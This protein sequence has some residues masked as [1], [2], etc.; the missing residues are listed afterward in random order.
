MAP[1]NLWEPCYSAKVPDDPQ[2]YTLDILWLQEEEE[3]EEEGFPIK[4]SLPQGPL[5]GIP[6]REMSH[7]SF[8]HLSKSPVYEP[9]PTNQVPLGW[10]GTPPQ[11]EMP[12]SGDFLNLSS[13]VPSEGAHP[14]PPPRSLTYPHTC[15]T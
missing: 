11:R 12:A 14:W 1:I 10:K 15:M 6:Q 7:H 13:R 8:I 4:G 2:T 5:H 3:E 9:P